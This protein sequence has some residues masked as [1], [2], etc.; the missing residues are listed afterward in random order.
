MDQIYQYPTKTKLA[1]SYCTQIAIK[2]A[3]SWC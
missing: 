1:A 2:M 3:W